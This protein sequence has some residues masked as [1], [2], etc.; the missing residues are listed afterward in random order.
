MS[1]HAVTGNLGSIVAALLCMA[2]A[3]MVLAP[4][5]RLG[6][7]SI[8]RW[9]DEQTL[10]QLHHISV[11]WWLLASAVA[12]LLFSTASPELRDQH[13][14]MSALAALL[15]GILAALLVLLTRIDAQCRLLPDPLTGLLATTG[16]IAHGL[17]LPP[18]AVSLSD[19][20]A[21][22]AAGYALLWL[23]TKIFRRLA[24]DQAMGRGDFAMS[25][26]LGAWLGWQSIAMVWLIASLCGLAVAGL[27][28]LRWRFS[29]RQDGVAHSEPG[30]FL[31]QHIAFG[32]AL[33]L[34][35][36]ITWIH[37]G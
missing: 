13:P 24:N 21:G 19:G 5:S 23:L 35:G 27:R 11:A 37:L 18:Q 10:H 33:A 30:T 12:L 6:N 8:A 9:V 36:I 14:A 28:H 32:P 15:I 22:C 1:S 20:I 26:G 31:K 4:L 29:H 16:L 3:L 2:I 25:A 34:G 17:E 7:R